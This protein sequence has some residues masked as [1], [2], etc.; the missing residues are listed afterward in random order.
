MSV[1][2]SKVSGTPKQDTIFCLLNM[3]LFVVAIL[4]RII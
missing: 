4:V 3:E 2:T 1:G